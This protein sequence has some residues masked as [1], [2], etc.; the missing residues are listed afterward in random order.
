MPARFTWTSPDSPAPA[1]AADG[2]SPPLPPRAPAMP[3]RAAV[4][5]VGTTHILEDWPLA[6]LGRVCRYW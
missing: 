5:S 6:I 1:K 2:L 4:N 3:L